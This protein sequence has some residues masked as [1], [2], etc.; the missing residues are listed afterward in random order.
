MFVFTVDKSVWKNTWSS[1]NADSMRATQEQMGQSQRGTAD[2]YLW[3]KG[4]GRRVTWNS[5]RH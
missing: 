3:G 2:P 5:V 1:I 4:G